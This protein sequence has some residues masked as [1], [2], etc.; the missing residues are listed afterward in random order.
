M[1]KQAV[2]KEIQ[3]SEAFITMAFLTFSGGLQDSYSYLVRGE[4]FANAQTGN[5]VLLFVHLVNGNFSKALHYLFPVLAFADGIFV[6]DMFKAKFKESRSIHWRQIILLLEI[7][8]LFGVV[9]IP[10]NH[11]MLANILIS[12]S[13]A[14]QVQAFRK[15]NGYAFA[16]TMC[17][18]NTRAGMEALCTYLRTGDKKFKEKSLHYFGVILLF[19]LGA[20]FGGIF[21]K[22][23]G[24]AMI[25][26][27]CI[28]LSV[29][30]ILMFKK[31][32][33]RIVDFHDARNQVIIQT[34]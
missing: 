25:I 30:F 22:Y 6:T 34:K 14:M 28:F 32:P 24:N 19:A 1:N 18:G 8:L 21:A 16:S 17:I 9:F 23:L 33:A 31:V 13:C 3:M 15:I 26:F 10:Q 5:I 2:K 12:F 20:G 11:N 4:V 7:G 29:S 27:S